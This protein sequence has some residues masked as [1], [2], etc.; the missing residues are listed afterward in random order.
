M[1]LPNIFDTVGN[2]PLIKL[3]H[4]S[5]QTGCSIFAKCEFLNP[6]G[7]VKDRAGRQILIDAMKNG[8]IKQGDTII[9]ATAGN[10]GISLT[11]L[12]NA[13]GLK[14]VI[15]MPETQAQGKKDALRNLGA[16]LIL[17]PACPL[18]DL[19]NFRNVAQQLALENDW[20]LCDQFNNPSNAQAHINTTAPEILEQTKG[21]ID[22]FICAV[23]TGG[24]LGGIASGLTNTNNSSIKIGIVDP[25][26]ANLFNYYT[27]GTLEGSGSSF[28]EGIGQ[29]AITPQIQSLSVDY[30]YNISDAVA[31]QSA[32]DCIKLEGINVGLSSGMN[33]AGAIA[34][35]CDMGEGHTIVTLLCDTSD[36]YKDK[37][38]NVDFL[39]EKGIPVP[40]WIK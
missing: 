7:S 14:T 35:A 19:R 32:Y 33:I 4:A 24:T 20:F 34:M 27:N 16:E 37:M 40:E 11:L 38:F 22:G 36:K 10:T 26:G 29:G 28:M 31:M 15:V 1:I 23:G 17:T 13:L 2:T 30:A 9:E 21:K 5:T 6:S 39:T 12:G 8:L 3:K 18:S 25:D